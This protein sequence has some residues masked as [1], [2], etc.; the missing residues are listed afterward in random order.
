MPEKNEKQ[1]ACSL[2][3]MAHYKLTN[4]AV[5]VIADMSNF[6]RRRGCMFFAQL[7]GVNA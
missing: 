6:R 7:F 5:T 1:A 3:S 2:L 4:A